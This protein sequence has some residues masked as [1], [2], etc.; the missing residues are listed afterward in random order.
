M[1]HKRLKLPV[2]SVT[3]VVC[4]QVLYINCVVINVLFKG[5]S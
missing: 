2:L 5:P 3:R 1:S 4:C